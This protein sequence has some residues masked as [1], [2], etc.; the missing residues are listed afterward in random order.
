MRQNKEGKRQTNTTT[1]EDQTLQKK[2]AL[3]ST[4]KSGNERDSSRLAVPRVF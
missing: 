1:N 2:E 3:C 4:V